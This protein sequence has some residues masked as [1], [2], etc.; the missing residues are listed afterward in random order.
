MNST[1]IIYSILSFSVYFFNF[2]VICDESSWHRNPT[3]WNEMDGWML[4]TYHD[5]VFVTWSMNKQNGRHNGSLIS[6]MRG[7]IST[8]SDAF[9]TFDF[10]IFVMNLRKRPEKRRHLT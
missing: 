10:P 5:A 6:R 3:L 8:V 1:N 2:S 4:Q 9:Q 7:E